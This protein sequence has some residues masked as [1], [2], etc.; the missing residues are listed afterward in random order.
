MELCFPQHLYEDTAEE[1]LVVLGREEFER[2]SSIAA[3][4]LG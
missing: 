3:R 4:I 2:V 1:P